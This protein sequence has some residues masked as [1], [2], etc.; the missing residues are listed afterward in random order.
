[1]VSI[2]NKDGFRKGTTRKGIPTPKGKK[3]KRIPQKPK[4]KS[5]KK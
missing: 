1:M 3:P 2:P 5:K 4:R